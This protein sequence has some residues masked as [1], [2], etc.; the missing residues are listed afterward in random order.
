M[1]NFPQKQKK[2]NSRETL[3]FENMLK[4]THVSSKNKKLFKK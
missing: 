3:K 4:M 1:P 2:N